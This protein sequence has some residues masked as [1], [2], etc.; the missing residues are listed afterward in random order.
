MRHFR[1]VFFALATLTALSAQADKTERTFQAKCASCHGEDGKG[2]TKKGTEMG[3]K[4]M[5]S[6]AWQKDMTDEKIQKGIE[7]GVDKTADGKKQQMDAYKDK[8]KP[9]EITA[10]VKYIRGL[11]GK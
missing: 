11:A 9:E 2:A 10:L 1:N 6:A 8:L 7:N 3:I 5:S 4:D